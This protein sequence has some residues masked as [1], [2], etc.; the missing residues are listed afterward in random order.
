MR[1]GLVGDAKEYACMEY[2]KSLIDIYQL[3]LL[4]QDRTLPEGTLF[5]KT[6]KKTGKLKDGSVRE[7]YYRD[8]YIYR[9][10]KEQYIPKKEREETVGPYMKRMLLEDQLKAAEQRRR[11][12]RRRLRNL[13]GKAFRFRDFESSVFALCRQVCAEKERHLHNVLSCGAF[14]TISVSDDY[15]RSRA[16][17]LTASVMVEAAL[18]YKYE[19]KTANKAGGHSVPALQVPMPGTPEQSV[20]IAYFGMLESPE[21]R[22]KQKHNLKAYRSEN[23][24]IGK[25]LICFCSKNAS[26]VNTEK[27][28]NVLLELSLYGTLPSAE[29]WLDGAEAAVRQTASALL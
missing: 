27:I 8:A 4:L 24:E 26:A 3:T 14:H 1:G 9:D 29:V 17:A 25:N 18:L 7:Y 11:T 21:S 12:Y 20:Y 13:Y 28:M 22:I 2:Q 23:I 5:Y 16:E 6:Y 15:V 10:H 19:T